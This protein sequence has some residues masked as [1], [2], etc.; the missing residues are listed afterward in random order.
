MSYPSFFDKVESIK[1][2]DPLSDILGSFDGGVYDISYK[3]IVKMAG[4]SC[5]TVGGAYLSTLKALKALYPD[6]LAVR[7]QVSVEIKES[8]DEG[9]A[10]VIGAVISNI[11]GASGVGG[12]KGLGG[13]FARNNLL[14]FGS[15]GTANIRFTRID[16]GKSVEVFYNHSKVPANPMMNTLMQKLMQ[17]LA[18]AEEKI[19]FGKLWQERVK[20]IL[21]DFKDDEE[22]CKVV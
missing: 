22:V 5:P 13:K 19:S 16:N 7:G 9:V 1:L 20:Q 14:K 12:F 8:E 4:H 11:T 6:G 10:G 17:G 3:E 15:D 2:K 18:S 21:I